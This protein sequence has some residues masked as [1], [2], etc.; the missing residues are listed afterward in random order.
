MGTLIRCH[1]NVKGSATMEKSIKF[2][3]KIK[4][5]LPFYPAIPPLDIYPKKMKK[6]ISKRYPHAHAYCSIIHNSKDMET[7]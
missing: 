5:E 1:G 4:I 6:Y 3:K 2:P 7:T